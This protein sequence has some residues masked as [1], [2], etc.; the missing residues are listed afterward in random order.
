[1]F[2]L[3]VVVSATRYLYVARRDR[4]AV[5]QEA[6]TESISQKS[7]RRRGHVL[8]VANQPLAGSDL[9]ERVLERYDGHVLVD[10]LAPVL[11]SRIHYAMSDTDRE[12][13]VARDRLE[14]SLAWAREQGAP[15]RGALG[16]PSPTTAIEDELRRFGA[17]EV[18][19]A[20]P[21]AQ[22]KPGKR[23]ATLSACTRTRDAR[24]ARCGRRRRADDRAC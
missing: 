4:R 13:A 23:G 11:T 15:A 5:V 6:A 21:Q 3:G 22:A 17:D 19:V 1:V 14:R 8:V 2:S 16:D 10:I 7:A 18:I 24:Y 12:L 9:R 20:T